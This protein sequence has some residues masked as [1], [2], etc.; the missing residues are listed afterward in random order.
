MGEHKELYP[1]ADTFGLRA[2]IVKRLVR[3]GMDRRQAEEALVTDVRDVGT[4]VRERLTQDLPSP[5]FLSR[6]KDRT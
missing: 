6:S 5:P 2:A 1:D 3:A 4:N